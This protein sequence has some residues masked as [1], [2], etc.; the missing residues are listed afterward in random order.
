[1]DVFGLGVFICLNSPMPVNEELDCRSHDIFSGNQEWA[2]SVG[3]IWHIHHYTMAGSTNDICR[4]L[5]AWN[6]VRADAQ[7]RGRGRFGRAFISNP[8]GLWLSASL[9]ALGASSLWTGFSLRVGASLL[10]Y[11]RTLGLPDA[12]LRW[13]N[14]LLCA[15]RKLAGLLIEQPAT[16]IIVVGIGLNITNQPWLESQ[17]LLAS[18]TSLAAQMTSPPSVEEVMRGIL[19]ELTQGH[20]QM[21]DGGIAAAID[22]LNESW[23]EFRP[24]ELTLSDGRTVYGSFIGLDP[25]GHLRIEDESGRE[26][27]IEHHFVQRLRE[28]PK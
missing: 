10:R 16:G 21:I 19:E 17:D 1:M 5:P 7:S 11:A 9:P 8:G 26:V 2:T 18:T 20:Q 13:P 6:A 27:V 25:S 4:A 28:L 15:D 22:E 12:R 14:D 3:R 24:V 23:T